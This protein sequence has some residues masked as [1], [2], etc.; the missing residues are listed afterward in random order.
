MINKLNLL[1][2]LNLWVGSYTQALQYFREAKAYEIENMTIGS[3]QITFN[4]TDNLDDSMFVQPLTFEFKLPTGWTSVTVT[5]NG[6]EIPFVA[7]SNYTANMAEDKVCTIIDG[8]LY[9]DVVPDAGQVV[10]VK[11]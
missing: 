4:V 11:K 3:S 2:E 7:G 6:V 1:E 10:I 8:V 9:F 5:Q